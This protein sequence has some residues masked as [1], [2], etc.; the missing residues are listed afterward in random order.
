VDAEA[1]GYAS[2][3][4][5]AVKVAKVG[6]VGDE[7][8]VV[9]NAYLGDEHISQLCLAANFQN[10]SPQFAGPLPVTVIDRKKRQT[11]DERDKSLLDGRTT[12]RL[13]KNDRRKPN[14]TA[15]NRGSSSA[16]IVSLFFS[17][18]PAE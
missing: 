17:R 2:L 11:Q 15:Q 4:P 14:L 7:G 12:Q 16:N 9:V 5:A 18:P 1:G 6:V 3:R 8:R 10:A 13:G